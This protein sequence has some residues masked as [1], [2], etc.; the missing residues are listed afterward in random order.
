MNYFSADW[1]LGDQRLQILNRHKLYDLEA[2]QSLRLLRTSII[3][4]IIGQ[5]EDG[6]T[7][8][9]LGDVGLDEKEIEKA[10]KMQ[11]PKLDS[12]KENV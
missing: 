8:W 2:K 12:E 7:L 9:H 6:D 5:L 3:F 4:E 11:K 1:H 10:I